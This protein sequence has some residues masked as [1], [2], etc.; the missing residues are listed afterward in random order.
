[1][2]KRSKIGC[3]SQNPGT[4]IYL[5]PVSGPVYTIFLGGT[6]IFDGAEIAKYAPFKPAVYKNIE[7]ILVKR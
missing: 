4:P 3:F 5:T 1:M 6:F 2:G 7:E